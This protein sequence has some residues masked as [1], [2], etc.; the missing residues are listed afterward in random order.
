M[1]MYT[2]NLDKNLKVDLQPAVL[3]YDFT[4][5]KQEILAKIQNYA[6]VVYD[7][8]QIGIAKKDKATLNRLAKEMNDERLRL[9]REFNEPFAKF[10]QD[11]KEVVDTIKDV[12]ADIDSQVK[13]Y[14][15][16]LKSEKLTLIKEWFAKEM[17]HYKFQLPFEV[18]FD[19]R[20]LNKTV[21]K[22]DVLG[23]IQLKLVM[24]ENELK[25]I[26]LLASEDEEI[27]IEDFFDHLDINRT[28]NLYNRLKSSRI[29]Q[30]TIKPIM[31]N[32]TT[33]RYEIWVEAT[34]SQLK[35]LGDVMRSNGIKYGTLK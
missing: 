14:E 2:M 34:E 22:E 18:L 11:V 27:L 30:T 29:N 23:D 35:K 6:G 15:D 13:E 3:T 21:E 10:K 19:D 31:E 26:K 24:I 7:E 25:T 1:G 17:K 5:L 20:W 33:I 4:K 16:R 8:D 28:L 32:E 12:S 9:E